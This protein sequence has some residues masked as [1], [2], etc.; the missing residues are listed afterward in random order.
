MQTVEPPEVMVKSQSM[1]PLTMSGSMA[2]QQQGSVSMPMA[3]TTT[4]NHVDVPD[5]DC[6]LGPC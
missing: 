5:L 6:C 4:K 3:H 1:L 2:V